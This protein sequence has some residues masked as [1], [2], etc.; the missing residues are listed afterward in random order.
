MS[1][2]ISETNDTSLVYRDLS[3]KEWLNISLE[4]DEGKLSK[5]QHLYDF[6]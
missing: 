1:K 5:F 4:R 6:S 2:M 3:T